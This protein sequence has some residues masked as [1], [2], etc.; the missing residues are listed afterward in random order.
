M[1]LEQVKEELEFQMDKYSS[2]LIGT[3]ERKP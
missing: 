2:M 3:A 1:T